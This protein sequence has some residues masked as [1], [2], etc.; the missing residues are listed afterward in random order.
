MRLGRGQSPPL[1]CN[2]FHKFSTL[3]GQAP[4]GDRAVVSPIE[5]SLAV[6]SF[7]ALLASGAALWLAGRAARRATEPHE[8]RA[9]VLEY[10]QLL[11]D[12]Q[13]KL[14]AWYARLRKRDQQV[15]ETEGSEGAQEGRSEEVEGED[16]GDVKAG[17]WRDAR[18]VL[19]N[20]R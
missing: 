7:F 17:L 18:R 6:A 14:G 15:Y 20:R 5:W 16:P 10:D 12:H 13:Q 3:D 2:G 9:L 19:A 11:T 4:L 8:L 1:L